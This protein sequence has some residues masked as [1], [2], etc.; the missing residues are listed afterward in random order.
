MNQLAIAVLVGAALPLATLTDRGPVVFAPKPEVGMVREFA[1]GLFGAEC[2]RWQ[3]TSID[4]DG[5]LVSKCGTSKSYI[6]PA[7]DYNLKKITAANG[8]ALIEFD[9]YYPAIKFPLERGARWQMRYNGYTRQDGVRW[10][11]EVVCKVAAWEPLSVAAGTFD[12]YRIECDDEI[13]TGAVGLIIHSTT[14]YAPALGTA[15][16]S[17]NVDDPRF[18]YELVDYSPK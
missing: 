2:A 15:I 17:V 1:T 3:V 5:Y 10:H 16:K 13:G 6:L 14:W 4:A 8:Q 11:G 18:D 9:P 7:H 12:T